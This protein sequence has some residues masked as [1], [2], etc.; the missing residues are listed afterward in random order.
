VSRIYRFT[1]WLWGSLDWI[2]P[3]VCGGCGRKGFR[4]CPDC[5]QRVI[6]VPDPVCQCCGVPL[7]RPGECP[8]CRESHPPFKAIRSW[9]VFEGP[10]R[11]A[12]HALKYRRNILLGSALAPN[13]AGYLTK[14][15]WHADVV[16]PVPLGKL[17]L[18]E[19]GYNQV[20]LFARPLAAAQD[21]QYE[22]Q[23]L[24][25]ERE[26]RSQVGLSPLERKENI[27][28]AFGAD[29]LHVSGKN[30]LLMD[31]VITTGATLAACADALAKAGARNIYGLTLARAMPYHGL[32]IV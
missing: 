20:G 26:T 16:I 3:P 32:Q 28:G 25:R 27:T 4:W 29:P 14:L 17:R 9:A 15:G 24:T 1:Q 11:N 31:D 22:P 8:S 30:I 23:A 6:R 7:L 18:K 21:W 2:F 5:Q 13:L 10:I 12:I 19:R